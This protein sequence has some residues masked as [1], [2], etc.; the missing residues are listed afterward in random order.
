MIFEIVTPF[1]YDP[2]NT[3][4]KCLGS[5]TSY[6]AND[7]WDMWDMLNDTFMRY[8]PSI[9]NFDGFE[10]CLRIAT[11]PAPYYSQHN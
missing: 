5:R 11:K 6:P 4:L 10:N 1:H 9:V 7:A 3:Y 2:N 8:T